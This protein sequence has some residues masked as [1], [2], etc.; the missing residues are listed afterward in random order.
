MSDELIFRSSWVG[1]AVFGVLFGP[2]FIGGLLQCYV[3]H[4]FVALLL[5][6]PLI[7]IYVWLRGF[8]LILDR[9]SLIYRNGLYLNGAKISPEGDWGETFTGSSARWIRACGAYAG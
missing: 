2:I 6:L 4:D 3:A 7:V 1:F 8:V 5:C 9:A